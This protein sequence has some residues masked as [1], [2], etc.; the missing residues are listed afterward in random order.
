MPL[1]RRGG[2]GPVQSTG[3]A[4]LPTEEQLAGDPL[5]NVYT[6]LGEGN[7]FA[8]G[9]SRP[10]I[11][12]IPGVNKPVQQVPDSTPTI[13]E[14]HGA[15]AVIGQTM[16]LTG[17]IGVSFA[18]GALASAIPLLAIYLGITGGSMSKG[19]TMALVLLL[20]VAMVALVFGIIS[21][22]RKDASKTA[23]II[24]VA[25]AV[26][27][28]GIAGLLYMNSQ[29]IDQS[30]YAQ[31]AQVAQQVQSQSQNSPRT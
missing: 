16:D 15:A 9:S 24:A 8:R 13:V 18:A 4:E 19:I 2:G 7:P 21:L 31:Q 25:L 12:H 26:M 20:F 29:S 23:G 14:K 5:E 6:D 1:P 17:V 10:S 27:S 11:R 28:L 30:L 22:L 3:L